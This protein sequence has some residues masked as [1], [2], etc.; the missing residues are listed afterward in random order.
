MVKT[1]FVVFVLPVA[2]PA[3]AFFSFV[4]RQVQELWDF[5]YTFCAIVHDDDDALSRHPSNKLARQISEV[6]SLSFSECHPMF[7]IVG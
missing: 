7:W 4:K 6:S 3:Y 5:V 2:F 1:A